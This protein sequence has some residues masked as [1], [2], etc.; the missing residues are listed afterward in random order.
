LRNHLEVVE[1]LS[2]WQG[3]GR[4]GAPRTAR[5]AVSLSGATV[6]LIRLVS[7]SLVG[8][9]MTVAVTWDAMTGGTT[10]TMITTTATMIL[11]DTAAS[12]VGQGTRA[13][14]VAWKTASAPTGGVEAGT[15]HQEEAGLPRRLTRRQ[16]WY[17]R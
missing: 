5:R 3:R 17:G 2:F 8:A 7:A 1:D 4:I 16:P 13:T 6:C 11:G 15:P 10:V 9:G 12:P 14:R